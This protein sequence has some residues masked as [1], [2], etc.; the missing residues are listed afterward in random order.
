MAITSLRHRVSRL[1]STVSDEQQ[2]QQQQRSLESGH[3]FS[4]ETKSGRRNRSTMLIALGAALLLGSCAYFLYAHT[5]QIIMPDGSTWFASTV[6]DD[7]WVQTMPVDRIFEKHAQHIVQHSLPCVAP[8]LYGRNVRLLSIDTDRH[9][10]NP[11]LIE[12]AAARAWYMEQQTS[13]FDRVPLLFDSMES[14]SQLVSNQLPFD[15]PIFRRARAKAHA[16]RCNE[17]VWMNATEW[18]SGRQVVVELTGNV[19]YCVQTMIYWFQNGALA[20]FSKKSYSDA[21]E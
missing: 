1:L 14:R 13:M 4:I 21:A 8:I 6:V 11:S 9:F 19:S 7:A 17:H 12:A 20:P 5:A 10:I 3:A 18:P 15:F 2:Q 16:R